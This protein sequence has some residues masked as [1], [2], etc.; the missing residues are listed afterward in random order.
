MI[1]VRI[2]KGPECGTSIDG[3]SEPPDDLFES[4]LARDSEWEIDYGEATLQE[5][6]DWLSKDLF[7]R[8]SRA[9][10]VRKL[11]VFLKGEQFDDF[12]EFR[13]R[14]GSWFTNTLKFEVENAVGYTIHTFH[15]SYASAL[16]LVKDDETGVQIERN[17]YTE[18]YSIY[19]ESIQARTEFRRRGLSEEHFLEFFQD[20]LQEKMSLGSNAEVDELLDYAKQYGCKMSRAF[21]TELLSSVIKQGTDRKLVW[22][23]RELIR[24]ATS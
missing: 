20:E 12:E 7:N 18:Q 4:L 8:C 13:D 17:G 10:R 11:P 6:N 16:S 9:L 24:T 5:R 15:G 1:V 21:L 14:Y 19:K 22:R 3:P 2:T 23:L